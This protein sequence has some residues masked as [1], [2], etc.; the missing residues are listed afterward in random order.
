[1]LSVAHK[2]LFDSDLSKKINLFVG[3]GFSVLSENGDG[4]PLPTGDTLRDK[5]VSHFNVKQYKS[6]DLA[7]VYAVLYADRRDELIA[8]I[9][10]TFSVE[11]FD[12]K[13]EQL[14]RLDL[15]HIYTTNIDD[16]LF[17]I[18]KP[19]S[20]IDSKVLHDVA[21]YGAPRSPESVVQYVALHGCIRHDPPDFVFSA[22]QISSAF[23]SDRETWYVFQR[24]LNAR[25][26]I[27]LGYGMKDAGVLQA[28]HDGA[29][30][31]TFNR[32]ML[33]RKDDQ[34]LKDL[35]GTLGFKPIIGDMSDFL[36]YIGQFSVADQASQKS[37]HREAVGIVPP[38]SHIAQ[39]PVRNFFMGA[40]PEWSDAYSNQIVRRTINS[41]VKNSI[42]LGKHVAV[43]G[44]PLSGKTTI[45][46]QVA[47]EL[48]SSM[49]CLFFERVNEPLADKVVSEQKNSGHKVVIFVDN[50]IDSRDAIDKFT[51][52]LD[53][54]IVC[55]EQSV[56]FDSA[57]LR[58]I[59]RNLD[60]HSSSTLSYQEL[61]N[62]ID[63]IPQDSRRGRIDTLDQIERDS[64]EVG[65]FESLRK[66]V[67]DESL[68]SRFRVKLAEF[69]ANDRPAFDV[70][71]MSCY[72]AACR[73]PVSF[74]MIY[75]FI[76]DRNK[77]YSNVYGIIDRIKGFLKEVDVDDNEDQEY[78]SVRANALAH[79]A[80]NI[81]QPRSFSRIFDRFHR[82][83]P[84]NVIVDYPVFRRY[85]YDNDFARK[86]FPNLKDGLEFYKRLVK[87]SD[88][89]YD[90]Q[91]GAIYL[92]KMKDFKPAFEWIDTAL[93]KSRGRVYSIR[94]THA[95]ILFEA[96]IDIVNSSPINK[97]A[98]N[99][100]RESMTVLKDCLEKDQ[101][102]FYHLLRFSDQALQ[103]SMAIDDFESRAWLVHA[104]ERLEVMVLEA[105]KQRSHAS[106]NLRK[107]KNLL[108]QVRAQL[109]RVGE[110]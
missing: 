75:M 38:V 90:Y 67:L 3:S 21:A 46:K 95:R 25:P 45:L 40:E 49:T 61:Q 83:V 2:G 28:I 42:L 50:A 66:H 72:V 16:L 31:T 96:N 26:T 91:H 101:R 9:K 100:I 14:M 80:L 6:L 12:G 81:C 104:R 57:N 73:V 13:Y 56:Y 69:E 34:G 44:V 78:F 98:I 60:V 20:G 37:P 55:A 36:D 87:R 88:S 4:V 76:D 18:F 82:A 105:E 58:S 63:S 107:Y 62:I 70:Y 8:F 93:S 84:D 51:S 97:T 29:T 77:N 17:K 15:S 41:E 92:S 22:G 11:N 27:F 47:A 32:W 59:N 89:P 71:M 52:D 79:I 64:E 110:R 103:Y 1:M 74:D 10:K 109:A 43:V 85:A 65:L 94:N 108:L 53:A 68:T 35:Y 39:R 5:I 19:K 23:A 86:A 24:E 54:Q 33:I 30:Y 99:G 48:S 106:Y 7:S 102:R